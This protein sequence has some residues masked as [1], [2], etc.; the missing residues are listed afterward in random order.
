M[1]KPIYIPEPPTEIHL[2]E[3]GT[4]GIYESSTVL[5]NAALS[6]LAA[7]RHQEATVAAIVGLVMGTLITLTITH[8]IF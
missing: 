7:I 5:S 3:I 1:R 8:S 6:Q 4:T 2:R